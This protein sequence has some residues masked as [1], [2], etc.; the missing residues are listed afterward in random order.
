MR[1][2]RV[3]IIADS[4]SGWIRPYRN[5]IDEFTY[6][7]LLMNHEKIDVDMFSR[8]GLT[9]HDAL[10]L[11][12]QDLVGRFYDDY[13]FSFGINDCSP[14]SYPKS[15]ANFYNNTLIPNSKI[16]KVYFMLYKIFTY[17][18]IK[19]V[20]SRIRLSRPW[21]NVENLS[22]NITKIIEILSKETDSEVLFTVP[23]QTSRRI[24]DV[25]YN[26]NELISEY[27][28]IMKHIVSKR[29]EIIDTNEIL[30]SNYLEYIP[31]GIHYSA[32]GHK[33]VYQA[34]GKK[35]NDR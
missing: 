5:H 1:K 30:K 22:K 24:V 11:N 20:L 29:V 16:E 34:I 9:R 32:S 17:R 21:I 12:W 23:S 33:L 3:A 13:I 2:I 7:E 25:L 35:I 14:R 27:S 28:E 15:M 31:E 4:T 18:I 10:I 19:W 6:G 8:T 26:V